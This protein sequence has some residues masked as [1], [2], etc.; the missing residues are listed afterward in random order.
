MDYNALAIVEHIVE[1]RQDRMG[2]EAFDELLYYGKFPF[3]FKHCFFEDAIVNK[4]I[5]HK[6]TSP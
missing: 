5:F 2:I 3:S 6:P 4:V 1:T